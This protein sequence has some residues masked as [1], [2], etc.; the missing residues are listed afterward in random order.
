M[1]IPEHWLH[2]GLRENPKSHEP[3]KRRCPGAGGGG[4]SEV[5]RSGCRVVHK[6]FLEQLPLYPY[7]EGLSTVILPVVYYLGQR[8]ANAGPQDAQGAKLVA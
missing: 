7:A 6:V 8:C 4:C 1:H 5:D 2:S 3:V